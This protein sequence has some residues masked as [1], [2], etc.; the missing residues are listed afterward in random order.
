MRGEDLLHEREEDRIAGSPPHAR[1]R[2]RRVTERQL[3]Q[4]ITPACAGKTLGTFATMLTSVGSPPHARGRHDEWYGLT[5]SD[6]IT[7]A[8]AGKT[9]TMRTSTCTT[10][11]HPRMRGEDVRHAEYLRERV[12]SPPH[13][14]GRQ[15]GLSIW[16][17]SSRI[18]PACAGKT[19]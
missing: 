5:F 12:G 8:C 1:G 7:P 11:D 13:A 4:R 14:R 9:S 19:P 10:R 16:S 3:K 18:T 2:R 17:Q 6:G 15:A